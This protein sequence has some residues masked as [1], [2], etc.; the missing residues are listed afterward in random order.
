LRVGRFGVSGDGLGFDI[1]IKQRA[2]FVGAELG[3]SQKD[4]EKAG[5]QRSDRLS[6]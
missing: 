4:C 2:L 5:I 1:D 3:E 6:E